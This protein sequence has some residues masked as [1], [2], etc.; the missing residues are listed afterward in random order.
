MT[1]PTVAIIGAGFSGTL[2]SLWLQALSP[3]GTRICLI[4]R[5]RRFGVGLAYSSDNP[6]HLLN[7]PAGRMSAFA[8]APTDFVDWLRR[9]RPNRLGDVLPT[10]SAFVPRRLYGAYLEDLL[11]RARGHDHP[12][13][14]ELMQ[15]D[16]VGVRDCA[17]G[18]TL[19]V[20]SGASLTAQLAVLAVGT[21][22]PRPLHADIL[23]LDKAGLWRGSPWEQAAF[24]AL[25][26]RASVLLIGTGLTMVD[27]VISLLDAGHTGPIHALSRHGLLPRRHAGRHAPAISLPRPLPQG[28]AALTR[29]IR[30]KAEEA[31]AAGSAWQPVVDSLRP[32]TQDIWRALS[33]TDRR[34]FVRHLR[35]WWDVHRHRIPPQIAD[36]IEAAED[37]GQLRVSAGR[38]VRCRVDDGHACVVF[39][40]REG[41]AVQVLHAA[42]V[43]DCTGSGTDITRTADPLL[44]ALLRRGAVR[45]DPLRL[46]LDVSAEGAA[47][48]GAGLAS[49]RLFAIGPLTK[50]AHWEIT[51]VPD[52]RG[53]CRD[54][55]RL[56]AQRLAESDP[57]NASGTSAAGR[58][59]RARSPHLRRRQN[60]ILEMA[61][62][63]RK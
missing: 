54:L 4:E 13:R 59:T 56:L 2:L 35:A 38:M 42:R 19:T 36:R 48:S 49:S 29:L 5:R 30:V 32:V 7:V 24:T 10:E 61:G 47:F 8:D 22:A 41:G 12:A 39:R 25:D 34:R 9:Q 44:Q 17:S 43:V 51:A 23:T 57:P 52:L 55:A 46:G 50:G 6:N 45:P 63:Q 33:T 60:A 31:I 16:V 20:A 1:Q 53:Q 15:D 18:V 40:R 58:T 11:Q 28:L 14:L 37:S 21:T 26:P 3:A 62:V 27:A